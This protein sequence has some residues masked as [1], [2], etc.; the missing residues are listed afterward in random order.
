MGSAPG[1]GGGGFGRRRGGRP[2]EQPDSAA[3]ARGRAIGLLARRDYPARLLRSRLAESGFAPDAVDAA[4]TMLEDE[5]LVNDQRYVEAAVAARTS[6]GQGPIR[7]ALELRRQGVDAELVAAAVNGRSPDW[8]ERAAELRR[9]RFGTAP[10]ADTRE[11]A[12][13]VRFLLQRGFGGEHVRHALGAGLG[14]DLDLDD[15]GPGGHADG[16]A[17]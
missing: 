17:E 11:R 12:R 10:P 6:R 4:V 2:P 7:I 8:A 16:E 3:A 1:R 14:P 9:R 13:Q 5:R 15:S